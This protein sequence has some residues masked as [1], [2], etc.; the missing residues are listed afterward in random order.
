M[1]ITRA[2]TLDDAERISGLLMANTAHRGGM[3]VGDWSVGAVRECLAAGQLIIIATDA[4]DLLGVLFT[5][6]KSQATA[7]PVVAMRAAWPGS[8]D[9]YVYGPVC[10]DRVARGRGV[11]EALYAEVVARRPGREAVLFIKTDNERSLRAHTRLGMVQVASF[12]LGAETFTV[13]SS[14]GTT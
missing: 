13:L 12:A 10:V 1:M 6:E 14:R 9:A 11:L 5:S 8:A 3:L 4:A 7:P 2:A